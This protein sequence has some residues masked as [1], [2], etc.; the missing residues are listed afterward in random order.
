[1]IKIFRPIKTVILILIFLFLIFISGIAFNE[2]N[3]ENGNI[4]NL[5]AQSIW[6]FTG[7]SLDFLFKG[8]SEFNFLNTAK[9]FK[10]KKDFSFSS[11]K[12]DFS[13]KIET[14]NFSKFKENFSNKSGLRTSE[15]VSDLGE[16]NSS[17]SDFLSNIKEDFKEKIE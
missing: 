8:I 4:I 16:N 12:D 6:S 5:K 2:V 11:L 1:M 7:N 17:W 13:E 9:E 10:V 15:P 3:G 14:I